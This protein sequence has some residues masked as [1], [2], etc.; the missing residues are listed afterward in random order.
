MSKSNPPRLSRP[1]NPGSRALPLKSGMSARHA[2]TLAIIESI[3]AYPD[4]LRVKADYSLLGDEREARLAMAIHRTAIQRWQTLGCLLAQCVRQ[5]WVQIEASMQGVLVAAAAQVVF[6]DRLP[7][8]AVIDESVKLA[9]EI[10]RPGAA[11]LAN[12][13]LRKLSDCVG[14]VLKE[15]WSPA[16][17]RIP[18][19]DGAIEL[20]M[21]WLPPVDPL[22]EHLAFA[23]SVPIELTRAW[24]AQH[25]ADKAILLARHSVLNPPII[26]AVEPEFSLPACDDFEPHAEKGFVVW[27]GTHEAMRTFL[28]A[29]PLRR[30][31]DPAS[32]HAVN[33]LAKFAATSREPIKLIVDFCAGRG[34]KTRQL[35]AA[36]PDARI[37]A[38]EPDR[39]RLADLEALAA[40]MP[41]IQAVHSESLAPLLH[42]VK[43]DVVLLDVPCSNTAVLARRPEAKYRVNEESMSSLLTLQ[44]QIL[45]L[46]T[47]ILR[48][49]GILIYSTCSLE[50]SENEEQVD[51]VN[52]RYRTK[53]LSMGHLLPSGE[54]GTRYHDGAFHAILRGR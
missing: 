20:R 9:R 15:P 22:D 30:V 1:Q 17:D 19:D 27:H 24:I 10:V 35:A 53:S 25:G 31:Q 8:Y 45:M 7:R 48:P 2:V 47:A 6:M 5:P 38:A 43:A 14:G 34:T 50:R 13:V 36:F 28:A 18:T 21:P 54:P 12:A 52:R 49:N 39:A 46:G 11:G 42:D 29:A 26:L 3:R 44:R 4:L 33:A 51:W 32:S 16:R 37:I 23:A 40:S 41:N